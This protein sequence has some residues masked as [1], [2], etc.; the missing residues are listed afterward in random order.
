MLLFDTSRKGRGPVVSIVVLSGRP[1][2][3]LAD[4]LGVLPP[5][6]FCIRGASRGEEGFPRG[7]AVVVLDEGLLGGLGGGVALPEGCPVILSGQDAAAVQ[8]ARERRLLPLDCGLSLR[9][10]LTLSSFTESSAVVSLQRPVVR[11][12]GTLL[13]PVELPLTLSR[14]WE[15]YPLLCCAGVLLVSGMEGL[16]GTG[17]F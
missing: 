10:T 3:R 1:H 13:E 8:F 5:E 14:R 9:D 6:H 12:D 15:S 17:I 11:L 2:C 7:R 4:A 16:A